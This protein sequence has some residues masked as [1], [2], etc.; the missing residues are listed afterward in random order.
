MKIPNCYDPV[1]Q[2]EQRQADWDRFAEDLPVCTL[3]RKRLYPGDRFHTASFMVVC[4]ACVEELTENIDIVEV[5][6]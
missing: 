6:G 5:E 2:E 3:C 4:P 1:A